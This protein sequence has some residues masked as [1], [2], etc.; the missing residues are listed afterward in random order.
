MKLFSLPN[1]SAS[2]VVE[3]LP[4]EFKTK[5][6]KKIKAASDK[7]SFI[8]WCTLPQTRHCFFSPFEGTIPGL[9]VNASTN[10]PI[11]LHG[12]VADYDTLITDDLWDSLPG[13]CKTEIMPAWG[14][15]TWSGGARL[16]WE[17]DEPLL[18][19]SWNIIKVFMKI[20]AKKLGVKKMFPG[21][22]TAFFTKPDQYY[23]VGRDWRHLSSD[24]IPA[25]ILWAWLAD[26]GD[27]CEEKVS[28]RIPIAEVAKE[29][30]VRFPNRWQGPFEPGVRGVRFWDPDADNPTA[31]IIRENGMQCFTGTRGFVTWPEIFGR[32]WAERFMEEQTGGI[33]AD[34]WYD[35]QNYWTKSK[36]FSSWQRYSKDD[37]KLLC[38]VQYG[39]SSTA[40]RKSTSS[41]FD[42]AAFQV[43]R[44]KR[45]DA[46][47]PR[48]HFPD[49]LVIEGGQRILN[50]SMVRCLPP[51]VEPKEWGED[52][53]WLKDFFD[54]FFVSGE[55]KD[56]FLAWLKWFYV[57]GLNR[58]PK[59][60][61]AVFIAGD[62]GV[63]KT[64]LSTGI[65]SPMVGG[66][67]DARTYLLGES[68]AFTDYILESPLLT[69]DDA[70]PAGAFKTQ[71]K[72]NNN[73]KRMVANQYHHFEKKFSSA[74]QTVWLGRIMVSCNLDHESLRILPSL[75]I[76][77]RDKVTLLQASHEKHGFLPLEKQKE[78]VQRELPNFCRWLQDWE[79]PEHLVGD[80]RF[81]IVA[82]HD[83]YLKDA[84]AQGETSFA[85][86][87]LLDEFR[88]RYWRFKEEKFWEGSATMLLSTL[89]ATPDLEVVTRPFADSRTIGRALGKLA[90]RQHECVELLSEGRQKIWRI[91][92]D[93]SS[94]P[95]KMLAREIKR[96][97]PTTEA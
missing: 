82:Y 44:Q 7:P 51:A 96:S 2:T 17:F 73:V 42:M 45:I 53:P 56:V 41:E 1:L 87:E 94:W 65:V 62:K 91:H 92:C 31:A 10:A 37:F 8:E 75:E 50:T 3:Q 70:E 23:E 20:A 88:V 52:F 60:G 93:P 13:R 55:Q 25:V 34:W 24:T 12:F 86:S 38:K 81:G 43:Q 71:I 59:S 67:Q 85:F 54:S 15:S 58:T 48:V 74:G 14:S 69:M 22:D 26:A 27:A 97:E 33:V 40:G 76:S 49:G 5:I 72:F 80:P 36:E 77:N 90:S 35:G 29:V 63:G 61:Q 78:L 18:L 19:T 64:F 6:P 21:F 9:R 57:N 32:R 95:Q 4:W 16:V 68:S 66:H 89:M 30:E 79:I 84:S 39:L 28:F 47:L 11:F 83:P 46:V